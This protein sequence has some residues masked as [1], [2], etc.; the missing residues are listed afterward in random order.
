MGMI[1]VRDVWTFYAA[2]VLLGIAE[3]GFFPGIILYL[4]YWIP[5]ADRARTGALF[6]MA[7]PV[8][9]IV[10]APISDRLLTLDGALGLHG[11]QWLFLMEGLPA[12]VLGF[13][14]LKCAD[15]PAGGCAVADREPARVAHA[16]NG[17]GAENAAPR[18]GHTSI[19]RSLRSGRVWLLCTVYFLNTI[20]TYGIFLWLPKMLTEAAG[21]R[22]SFRLSLLTTLPFAAALARHVSRRT[23]LRSHAESGNT[24]WPRAR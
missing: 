1:F 7:A 12:V 21:G 20:V 23:P 10:G 9:I 19:L 11:W 15:R 2:R 3:A 14:A 4:T 6:M 18:S 24:M 17:R 8:A 22:Q 16:D 13:V 5:A